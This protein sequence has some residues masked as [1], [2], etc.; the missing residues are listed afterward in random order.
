MTASTALVLSLLALSALLVILTLAA[1]VGRAAWRRR[2][3]IQGRTAEPLRPWLLQLAAGEAEEVEEAVDAVSGLPA[4]QWQAIEPSVRAL[5]LKVRGDTHEAVV[6][7]LR[8]RGVLDAAVADLDHRRVRRRALAAETLGAAAWQ[9]AAEPLLQRLSDKD[10]DVRVVAARAL[11]R[12]ESAQAIPALLGSI[13]H[14]VPPRVVATAMLAIAEAHPHTHADLVDAFAHPNPVARGLAVEVVGLVGAL[15]S[16]TELRRLL[17]DHD[18]LDT[19]IRAARALGRCGLPNARESL[20]NAC[21]PDRPTPLRAVAA[22]ALADLAMLQSMP[23]FERMVR[24]GEPRIA[25]YAAGG[26]VACGPAGVQVL[27][28]IRDDAAVEPRSRDIAHAALI[29]GNLRGLVPD[30]AAQRIGSDEDAPPPVLARPRGPSD[31]WRPPPSGGP[32]P[33]TR[34][35]RVRRAIPIPSARRGAQ[36]DLEPGRA[37]RGISLGVAPA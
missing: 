7:V 30:V 31:S 9:P 20:E 1:V 19:R 6:E 4:D 21:E 24:A 26:L 3:R 29:A 37:P 15:G 12:L 11:G 35:G 22:R 23:A 18:D 14:G 32:T 10:E 33:A 34:P 5:L 36:S 16:V 8:R 13:E 17:A 2:D 25:H 27:M 28:G